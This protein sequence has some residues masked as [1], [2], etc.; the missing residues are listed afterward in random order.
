[1]QAHMCAQFDCSQFVMLLL[2]CHRNSFMRSISIN[3]ILFHCFFYFI[4]SFILFF[5][6]Y[7]FQIVSSQRKCRKQHAAK[8]KTDWFPK[9]FDSMPFTTMS[10]ISVNKSTALCLM[11][12]CALLMSHVQCASINSTTDLAEDRSFKSEPIGKRSRSHSHSTISIN[13]NNRQ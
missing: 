7:F 12:V 11:V 1:M 8:E 3:R 5:F 4:H 10:P 6:Q 2:H 13:D 9:T